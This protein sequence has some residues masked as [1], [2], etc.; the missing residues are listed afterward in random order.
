MITENLLG[1]LTLFLLLI[2]TF[3]IVKKYPKTKNFLIVAIFLRSLFVILDQYFIAL[4]DSTGDAIIFEH[5]AFF[6]SEKYGMSIIFNLFNQ[7][8]FFISKFIS[9][10]YTLLD[11]S[12]M[13]VKMFS[14]GFGTASVFLIYRLTFILWGSHAASKAGWFAA[15]FPSL[16]L[17]SSLIL[18]EVYVIFFLTYALINFVYFL[19]KGKITYF[20][21][22]FFGFFITSLFH[23]PMILG[24]FI[25][26]IYIFFRILKK[27]NYFLY[28]KKKNLYLLFLLPILLTPIIAFFLG[29]YSI[30]KI[31]D[32]KN[33]GT[34]KDRDIGSFKDN[35]RSKIRNIEDILIWKIN[36]ATKSSSNSVSGAS[37]PLW[38]IPNDMK[39]IIYLTPVRIIYFLY[40]P[41]P[42]DVKRFKH[43]VG[44]FDAIFYIYLSLCILQNRKILLEDSR[45]RFLIIILIMY[46]FVYSFGVGNFGT[47]IRHRLKFIGILI[48]IAAPKIARI[49]FSKIK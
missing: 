18:R 34:F 30:P 41:F 21:K 20:I 3:F 9:I 46:V 42:W 7:D 19:D 13:M 15:L 25:F 6:Y 32:I 8:S 11:R 24:F 33:I 40:A 2:V 16:I 45:T 35:D 26:L 39:E 17:Y 48:A 27:N 31:G 47:G 23:G 1:W 28:F 37:Y 36:K 38:T 49:K 22:V 5:K 14:V 44:L 43:L 10:F 12:D 4:P 29:Y